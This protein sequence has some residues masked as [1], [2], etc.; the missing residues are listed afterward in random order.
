MRIKSKI[1]VKY[2][3][4]IYTLVAIGSIKGDENVT[5][6]NQCRNQQIKGL[7]IASHLSHGSGC[8]LGK[9]YMKNAHLNDE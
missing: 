8:L 2:Q 7:A 9:F 6:I 3:P 5:V 4:I 1:C